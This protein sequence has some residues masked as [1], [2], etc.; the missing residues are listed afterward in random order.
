MDKVVGESKHITR[1]AQL[2]HVRLP[3]QARHPHQFHAPTHEPT[4]STFIRY[5]RYPVKQQPLPVGEVRLTPR[6]LKKYRKHHHRG[7][8]SLLV[9]CCIATLIA[10]LL[11]SQGNGE[12][13]AWFADTFRAVFGPSVTA[14]IESWYLGFN[15]AIHQAQYQLN[16]KKVAAPW[17]VV[18]TPTIRILP[19][20]LNHPGTPQIVAM[21][22]SQIPP[23]VT[24]AI[25]GEGAWI[26]QAAA[27]S[28]YD[29]L[30]LAAKTFLRPDPSHPYALVTLLQ[31]DSRFIALHMVA[32][33]SPVGLLVFP[34]QA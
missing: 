29:Y 27:P 32:G 7:L 24:P 18:P 26:V 8:H 13:G 34:A 9:A 12:G 16:G 21:D 23:M 25:D 1:A 5:T 31:F 2:K 20:T 19:N 22:L 11:F 28:P 33:T 10:V 6:K 4:P 17:K 15:D 30:P 3:Y 14:Q